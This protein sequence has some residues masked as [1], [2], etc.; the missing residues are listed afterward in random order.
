MVRYAAVKTV[1]G[2]APNEEGG[3][4]A[5]LD[6]QPSAFAF[7]FAFGFLPVPSSAPS[8]AAGAASAPSGAGAAA[9]ASA[10]VAGWPGDLPAAC[11]CAS[12]SDCAMLAL[13]P[14]IT[15]GC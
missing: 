13:I 15:S 5:A 12:S 1:R 9:A 6:F 11:I 10:A 3:P 14:T 7:F 2:C 4:W 8:A